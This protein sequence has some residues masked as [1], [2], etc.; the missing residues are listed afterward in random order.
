MRLIHI[1]PG[2]AALLS[3]QLPSISRSFLGP[4]GSTLSF[5]PRPVPPRP[6]PPLATCLQPKRN[7]DGA[8]VL[9]EAG[10]LNRRRRCQHQQRSLARS[11]PRQPGWH[12]ELGTVLAF[13]GGAFEGGAFEGGVF[14]GGGAFEGGGV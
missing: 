11:L 12:V 3:A 1:A 9:A 4:R 10:A 7:G 8:H 2:G 13:E 14:E 5:P 6:L